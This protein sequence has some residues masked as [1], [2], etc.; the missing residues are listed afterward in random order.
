[1]ESAVFSGWRVAEGILESIG[2]PERLAIE[3]EE[4]GGFF[5]ILQRASKW[6]R[7]RA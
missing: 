5:R 6:A 1:M 7:S 2:R 3:H 4:P